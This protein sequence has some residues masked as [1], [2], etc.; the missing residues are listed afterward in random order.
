MILRVRSE[1]GTWRITVG[2]A[3][4]TVSDVKGVIFAEK[5]VPVD[6]QRLSSDPQ[7]AKVLDDSGS[8]ASQGLDANGA[9]LYL[10]VEDE[11]KPAAAEPAAA[12][13]VQLRSG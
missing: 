11:A 9:M 3:S 13:L 12:E 10:T 5:Q 8:L 6:R 7:G 2:S 4:S 1:A